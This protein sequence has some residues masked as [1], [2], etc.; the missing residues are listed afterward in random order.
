MSLSL[1]QAK[2]I[3]DTALKF[4]NDSNFKPL[5]IVILD[6]R[7]VTKY[8]LVEDSTSLHRSTIAQ[9]KAYG[10]VSMGVGTRG[11]AKMAA[12]RPAFIEAAGNVIGKLVPVAGGVLIK[13]KKGV[14]LG[15]IGVS[16]ETSDNDELAA[17]KGIEAAGLMADAG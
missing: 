13:D 6:N 15:A 16:G 3:G 11:L 2:K 12:E 5:A 1:K 8:Q 7:G 17:I 4:A 14:L 10:A 9:G